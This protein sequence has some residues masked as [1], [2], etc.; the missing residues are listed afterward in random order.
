MQYSNAYRSPLH[1]K[2]MSQLNAQCYNFRSSL[3]GT[4]AQALLRSFIFASGDGDVRETA[5]HSWFGNKDP[6]DAIVTQS[7]YLIYTYTR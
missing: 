6:S 7:Y 1:N 3:D 5:L 4:Y 2:G